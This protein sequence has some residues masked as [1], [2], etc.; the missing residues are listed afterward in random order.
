M[1]PFGAI[2]TLRFVSS[3]LVALF[4]SCL[5]R[6]TFQREANLQVARLLRRRRLTATSPRVG[7]VGRQEFAPGTLT[8]DKNLPPRPF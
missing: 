6:W 7:P 4:S 1:Q 2:V 5:L 8:F 3:R